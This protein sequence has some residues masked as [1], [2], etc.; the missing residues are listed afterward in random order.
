MFD[1]L[2]ACLRAL[3]PLCCDI[4]GWKLPAELDPTKTSMKCGQKIEIKSRFLGREYSIHI[5]NSQF[6]LNR[7]IMVQTANKYE[8]LFAEF[9]APPRDGDTRQRHCRFA[10]CAEVPK[11]M[12]ASAL[13][14]ERNNPDKGWQ[15]GGYDGQWR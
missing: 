1:E 12:R 10:F 2:P 6:N 3:K 11:T 13:A 9:S 4:P 8:F 7:G 5:D 14:P 15:Q